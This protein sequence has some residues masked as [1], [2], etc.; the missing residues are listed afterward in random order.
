MSLHEI[1]TDTKDHWRD[2]YAH[3]LSCSS[4]SATGSITV[5]LIITNDI[6]VIGSGAVINCTGGTG[7]F[8]SI[9]FPATTIGETGLTNYAEYK[10]VSTATGPFTPGISYNM[11][12]VRNGS[13]VTTTLLAN[14]SAS[15]SKFTNLSVV[16]FCPT[17]Y[18]PAEN[19]VLPMTVI[20]NNNNVSG[21]LS[22]G[23]SGQINMYAGI[24]SGFTGAGPAGWQGFSTAWKTLD[25]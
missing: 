25:S 5:P 12:L 6:E 20:N 14:S 18:R 10:L 13:S 7:Y 19:L 17:G 4:I 24:S 3:S 23:T 8:K 11:F 9:K 21:T 15:T 1:L 2:L 22:V 16:D